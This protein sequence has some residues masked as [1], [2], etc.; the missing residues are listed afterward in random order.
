MKVFLIV[1]P[2]TLYPGDVHFASFPLGIGYLSGILARDGHQIEVLDCVIENQIPKRLK[3]NT[4]HVGLS[5]E[6]IESRIS[7]SN[8]DIVGISCSYSVDINNAKKIAQIAKK[9]G[10]IPVV[11]GGAH[12]WDGLVRIL[13]KC[14]ICS[15]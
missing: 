13:P 14:R 10:K 7:K 4:Y 6:E 5:W 9:A 11:I 12:S 2:T 1:P 3:N 15:T 8:P